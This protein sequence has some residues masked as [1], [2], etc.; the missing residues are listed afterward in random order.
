LR[1]KE[2]PTYKKIQSR[3]VVLGYVEPIKQITALDA[4]LNFPKWDTE[5]RQRFYE[6]Q[7]SKPDAFAIY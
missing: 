3:D 2:T 5:Q 6:E 7:C 1:A 4:Y